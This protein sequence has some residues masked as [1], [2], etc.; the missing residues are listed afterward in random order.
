MFFNSLL[1]ESVVEI[2]ARAHNPEQ[3]EILAKSGVPFVEISVLRAEEFRRDIKK[4]R[5]HIPLSSVFKS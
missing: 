2:G 5:A 4:L 1:E 3:A